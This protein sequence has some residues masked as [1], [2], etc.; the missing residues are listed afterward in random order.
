M[1]KRQFRSIVGAAAQQPLEEAEQRVVLRIVIR[2]VAHV[3]GAPGVHTRAVLSAH[4][5]IAGVLLQPVPGF[6]AF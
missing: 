3:G 2:R 1:R 4:Y 6:H 5:A